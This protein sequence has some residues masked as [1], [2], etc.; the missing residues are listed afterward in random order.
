MPAGSTGYGGPQFSQIENSLKSIAVQF[1]T[2]VAL[3]SQLGSSVSAWRDFERELTLTNAA[4]EGNASTWNQLA[5]ASRNMALASKYSQAEVAN[6]FYNLVSAGLSIKEALQAE[7]GVVLLAQASLT[8]LGQASDLTAS[9]M[10]QFGLKSYEAYRISN[11]FIAS[12]NESLGTVNKLAYAFKQVGPIA[13]QAGLDLEHTTGILDKLFDAGLRGEQAGTVLRNNISRLQDPRG[14]GGRILANYGIDIIDKETGKARDYLSVMREIAKVNPSQASLTRIVGLEGAV[15]MRIQIE[16]LRKTLSNGNS[17]LDDHIQKITNTDAAYRQAAAQMATTDGQIILLYNNFNELRIMIGEGL[18]PTIGGLTHWFAGLV[19]SLRDTDASVRLN[20][21]SW[22]LWTGEIIAAAKGLSMLSGAGSSAIASIGAVRGIDRL[23][24]LADGSGFQ[25]KREAGALDKT[26]FLENEGYQKLQTAA[27]AKAQEL[28]G[29]LTTLAAA[30]GRAL[31]QLEHDAIASAGGVSKLSSAFNSISASGPI[32]SAVGSGMLKL[33]GAAVGLGAVALAI[34]EIRQAI[35][36]VNDAARNER[37]KDW[38]QSA[39]QAGIDARQKSGKPYTDNEKANLLDQTDR[40]G[41]LIQQADAVNKQFGVNAQDGSGSFQNLRAT[42]EVMGGMSREVK[43]LAQSIKDVEGNFKQ[44]SANRKVLVEAFTQN[45]QDEEG[46]GALG[47]VV[48]LGRGDGRDALTQLLADMAQAGAAG[49][50]HA[51]AAIIKY[52]QKQVEQAK[53]V[54]ASTAT[55]TQL[56]RQLDAFK[57]ADDE[58][59]QK[60]QASLAKNSTRVSARVSENGLD[61]TANGFGIESATAT[62]DNLSAAIAQDLSKLNIT[63]AEKRAKIADYVRQRTSIIER[64]RA[65]VASI[66]GKQEGYGKEIL[67]VITSDTTLTPVE[68][69]KLNTQISAPGA[70]QA[71]EQITTASFKKGDDIRVAVAKFLAAIKAD[72]DITEKIIN[73]GVE[74]GTISPIIDERKVKKAIEAEKARYAKALYDISVARGTPDQASLLQAVNRIKTGE[75]GTKNWE[76]F[77]ASLNSGKDAV[78]EEALTVIEDDGKALAI[79]RRAM[80]AFTRNDQKEYDLETEA[81]QKYLSDSKKFNPA[82]MKLFKQAV[83]A[84]A[85]TARANSATDSIKQIEYDEKLTRALVGLPDDDELAL[86]QRTLELKAQYAISK[87]LGMPIAAAEEAFAQSRLTYQKEIQ[88]FNKKYEG[89][90]KTLTTELKSVEGNSELAD[91]FSGKKLFEA[92]KDGSTKFNGKEYTAEALQTPKGMQELYSAVI[93]EF[94][95]ATSGADPKGVRLKHAQELLTGMFKQSGAIIQG[96]GAEMEVNRLKYDEAV[97]KAKLF[98]DNFK[99]QSL[100]DSYTRGFQAQLVGIK[101]LQDLTVDLAVSAKI[102]KVKLDGNDALEKLRQSSLEYFK[103]L[104]IAVKINAEGNFERIPGG[105]AA[106]NTTASDPM[107]AA[108]NSLSDAALQLKEAATALKG[109]SI[110][111]AGGS[112]NATGIKNVAGANAGAE[113]L[114]NY[115]ISLGT[116]PAIAAGFLGNFQQE[117]SMKSGNENSIGA[118]GLAQLLG[119]RKTEYAAFSEQRGRSLDDAFNQIDFFFK[120]LNTTEKHAASMIAKSKTAA[121][122]AYAVSHFYERAGKDETNDNARIGYAN[123]YLKKFASITPSG[124]PILLDVSVKVPKG[125]PRVKIDKISGPSLSGGDNVSTDPKYAGMSEDAIKAEIAAQQAQYDTQKAI[126]ARIYKAIETFWKDPKNGSLLNRQSAVDAAGGFFDQT[127]GQASGL[128]QRQLQDNAARTDLQANSLSAQAY[129]SGAKVDYLPLFQAV[130]AQRELD[131]LALSYED[132]IN[133]SGRLFTTLREALVASKAP[134]AEL[135]KLSQQQAVYEAAITAEMRKQQGLVGT[136]TSSKR[137]SLQQDLDRLNKLGNDNPNDTFAGLRAGATET[138]LHIQ[139][140]FEVASQVSQQAIAGFAD[141]GSSLFLGMAGNAKQAIAQMLASIAKLI[142]Q[143]LILKAIQSA[144]GFANGGIG[145]GESDIVMG[146][147]PALTPHFANG[148][149]GYGAKMYNTG[150]LHGAIAQANGFSGATPFNPADLMKGGMRAPHQSAIAI[151]GEG[152]HPEAFIPMVDRKTI[153]IV[154][155]NNGGGFVPLP[156][157]QRIPISVKGAAKKY[158]EGGIGGMSYGI[159]QARKADMIT[160]GSNEAVSR[161]RSSTSIHTSVNNKYDM[162]GVHITIQGSATKDD[163]TIISRQ[164][165]K[166]FEDMLDARE[167]EQQRKVARRQ[168]VYAAGWNN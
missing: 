117:S 86:A 75:D 6:S 131:A 136:S 121:Q 53:A 92:I 49:A 152:Q 146:S 133:K 62:A 147:S 130:Q 112:L 44:L 155:D 137:A 159:D 70:K 125:S 55:I 80:A 35:I 61:R 10:A 9:T 37:I 143:T 94:E 95:K 15:G 66:K 71:L 8:D 45:Q 22:G 41:V 19:T 93:N 162:G 111:E 99:L 106:N 164:T 78:T 118:Y 87:Y 51:K 109:S 84:A 3:Q 145:G 77:I 46:I 64:S 43:K 1:T 139:S 122:A 98:T 4:A 25:R 153:P 72:K 114:Y 83:E 89:Y 115:M 148:G 154:L 119:K 23:V 124:D 166:A 108:G 26:I 167:A 90:F 100:I 48:G 138:A 79:F 63:E 20:Y 17:V 161:G 52:A 126:Q 116:R 31:T 151:F 39:I 113:K 28:S 107:L 85:Q 97:R 59:A 140:E 81:L 96:F 56:S 142:I 141:A 57:A 34:Y 33:A 134:Q 73:N 104:G 160:A 24:P 18:A 12:T 29:R 163:A 129:N 27:T 60:I 101:P 30:E 165:M 150:G 128:R 156:S 54:G 38:T 2:I 67:N 105:N 32:I 157:G 91:A 69:A 40:S 21:V 50:D 5:D 103:N 135:D 16:A 7:T 13:A 65:L 88:D 82:G 132:T 47:Y 74:Q 14:L 127:L 36:A 68:L 158:A 123:Y 144:L 58:A 76:E 102:A 11:L 42:A 120:E 149:V 110:G 168:G